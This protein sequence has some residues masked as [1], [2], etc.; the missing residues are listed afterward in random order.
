[1]IMFEIRYCDVPLFSLVESSLQSLVDLKEESATKGMRTT[2]HSKQ[3][4]G[5]LD[6]MRKRDPAN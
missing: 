2:L 5:I 6:N 4:W 1:M 3:Q